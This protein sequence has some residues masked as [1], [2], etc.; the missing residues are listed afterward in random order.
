MYKSLGISEKFKVQWHVF[1][2]NQKL[3]IVN[4]NKRYKVPI[5]KQEKLWNKD[6]AMESN[7][8]EKTLLRSK[9]S[10]SNNYL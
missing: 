2:F 7:K 4:K 6:E 8:F 3:T 10:I 5:K 1:E 9:I